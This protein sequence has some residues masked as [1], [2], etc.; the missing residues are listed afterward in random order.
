MCLDCGRVETSQDKLIGHTRLRGGK[1][2]QGNN[3]C[4]A[5]NT[6]SNIIL[7]SRFKTDF[8]EIRLT[9]PDGSFVNSKKLAYTLGVVFTK[10]LAEYLAIEEG[11]LGFGIKKYKG[12]LTIFIYDNAKGGAGYASQF[13]LLTKE[14]LRKSYTLLKDCSCNQ[15]G[16]T[17]CIIDRTTQWHLEDLDSAAAVAWLQ[18]ATTNQLPEALQNTPFKINTIFGSLFDEIKSQNYHYGIKEVN[19]HVHAN[20]AAW[21]VENLESLELLK[22]HNCQINFI[23]EGGL[24]YANNQEKLTVLM[25]S[26]HYGLLKGQATKID[27]YPVHLSL[28]LE[29]ETQISYV[30]KEP[31]MNLEDAW[32]KNAQ[33]NFYKVADASI[34][35]Y[36]PLA[37]P[38]LNHNNLYES[39]V[40]SIPGRQCK[41]TALA[42]LMLGSL[43]E[44]EAFL[45]AIKGRTFSVSY[46]DK[47]N[48]S[49]FSMRLL[50]QFVDQLQHLC[51]ITVG[52]LD[53]HL[54]TDVFKSHHSPMYI[55]HGYKDL[56][57]YVY[58][59]EQLSHAYDFETQVS[60]VAKLPHYRFLEFKSETLS[61]SIR[62]DGGIAHGFKPVERLGS[63]DMQY[64]DQ[65]FEIRK[66]V[67][68][69]IIYNISVEK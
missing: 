37:L 34:A 15:T 29:N 44:K 19:I 63:Y 58:D 26:H 3:I 7:G 27:S 40:T 16:C 24:S 69:D 49:E 9:N 55:I 64:K 50:L 46:R 8:T 20:C 6:K 25:L 17:K 56:E 62:I 47:Y 2:E 33:E 1:N 60:Q 68:H 66:D 23:V 21:E 12:Y 61:F 53:I 41:S 22:R 35:T 36:A 14:I 18:T 65:V 54:T 51:E 10:S 30:S 32:S 42:Q 5:K 4:A 13:S 67:R 43:S 59:V 57:A 45:S 11:E 39:R 52:Q 38:E 31:Y 48:L 28:V